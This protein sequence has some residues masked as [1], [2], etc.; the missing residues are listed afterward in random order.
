MDNNFKHSLRSPVS[1]SPSR[2]SFCPSSS[3][4]LKVADSVWETSLPL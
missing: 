2:L 3:S 4:S 1:L